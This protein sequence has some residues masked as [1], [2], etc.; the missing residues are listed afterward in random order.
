MRAVDRSTRSRPTT[1]Q[2]SEP[3]Q[4]REPEARGDLSNVRDVDLP[5]D[6]R[7]QNNWPVKPQA[8]R[9]ILREAACTPVSPGWRPLLSRAGMAVTVI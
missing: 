5:A 9:N 3:L 1:A 4:L 7:V 6:R 2:G 8:R